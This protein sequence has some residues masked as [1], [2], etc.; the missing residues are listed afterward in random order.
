MTLAQQIFFITLPFIAVIALCGGWFAYHLT[1]SDFNRT[2][3]EYDHTFMQ[4]MVGFTTFLIFVLGVYAI[5]EFVDLTKL[6][7]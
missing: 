3:R 7:Y 1:D 5:S 6:G 2:C 4:V